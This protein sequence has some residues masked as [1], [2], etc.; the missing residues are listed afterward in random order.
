MLGLGG[1]CA[2]GRD[3]AAW[4]RDPAQ[5]T[6][7]LRRGFRSVLS[8][9]GELLEA[10]RGTGDAPNVGATASPFLPHASR[11]WP[12]TSLASHST[13]AQGAV[14]SAR[15]AG[16]PHLASTVPPPR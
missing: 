15:G 3:A 9:T 12:G 10:R 1:D 13:G 11:A 4:L 2:Q 7:P 8:G 6:S 5:A 16:S 14:R